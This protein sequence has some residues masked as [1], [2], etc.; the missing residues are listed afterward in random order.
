MRYTSP[1][2]PCR[3]CNKP[4]ATSGTRRVFCD[5]K[6]KKRSDDRAYRVRH[7]EQIRVAAQR[8]HNDPVG[9]AKKLARDAEYRNANRQHLSSE[10]ARRWRSD[11]A[12]REAN[13]V[14][15]S[16]MRFGLVASDFITSQ[17]DACRRCGLTS[18][19]SRCKWGQRLVTD[20]IDNRGRAVSNE[21][22]NN[23]PDNLQVLCRSCHATKTFTEDYRVVAGLKKVPLKCK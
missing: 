21:A 11:P 16:R 7:A 18:E 17:G 15:Q 10:A 20:H 22:R 13:H 23:D 4:F 5:S 3:E 14:S 6:C 2:R 9:H 1:M 19:Q 12:R 8:R